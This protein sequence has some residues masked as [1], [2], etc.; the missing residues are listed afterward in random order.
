MT[1]GVRNKE[2]GVSL[3]EVLIAIAVLGV[4]VLGSADFFVNMTREQKRLAALF[5]LQQIQKNLSTLVS[6]DSA[7]R[8]I[9]NRNASLACLRDGASTPCQTGKAESIALFTA[10]GAALFD[11][12]AQGFGLDGEV[13]DLS[14]SSCKIQM[15]LAVEL[16]CPGEPATATCGAPDQIIVR[17]IARPFELEPGRQFMF[18]PQNYAINVRK[19]PAHAATASGGG[20][21]VIEMVCLAT[22]A[23][24]Q[25]G[26]REVDNSCLKLTEA[27]GLAP[28]CEPQ[29]CPPGFQQIGALQPRPIHWEY[30][31]TATVYGMC[32]RLC[33]KN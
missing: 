6:S 26:H 4:I 25:S 11:P 20:G 28:A 12:A 21:V 13:C 22:L 17:G 2:A 15:D 33:M 14:L 3:I 30:N 1:C 18:N 7:W 24:Y 29:V 32:V 9:V 16:V 27:G 19:D 10:G 23:Y 5:Q 8:E 31:G